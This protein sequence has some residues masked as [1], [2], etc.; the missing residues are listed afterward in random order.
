MDYVTME[1]LMYLPIDS[2]CRVCTYTKGGKQ[3]GVKVTANGG[4]QLQVQ[5]TAKCPA[6]R[7]R[8]CASGWLDGCFSLLLLATGWLDASC[9]C[10]MAGWMLLATTSCYWLARCFSLCK[11]LIVP[12][13]PSR[14]LF[15]PLLSSV[16]QTRAG[17]SDLHA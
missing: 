17:D 3:V 9:C 10:W 16:A 14:S 4:P 7:Q 12:G 2:A 5:G 1:R 11:G 8:H 6:S 15:L 13:P